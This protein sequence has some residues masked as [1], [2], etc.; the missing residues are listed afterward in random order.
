[1]DYSLIILFRDRLFA[2]RNYHQNETATLNEINM[3]GYYS[4]PLFLKNIWDTSIHFS[5]KNIT[6]NET[7]RTRNIFDI[8]GRGLEPFYPNNT[9]TSLLWNNA[10]NMDFLSLLKYSSTLNTSLNFVITDLHEQRIPNYFLNRD[11]YTSL[12][13]SHWQAEDFSYILLNS[14]HVISWKHRK[15]NKIITTDFGFDANLLSIDL[16]EYLLDFSPRFTLLFKLLS[17]NQSYFQLELGRRN[18]K[19]NGDYARFLSDGYHSA[20]NYIWEDANSNRQAENNEISTD[21][22]STTGSKYHSVGKD[23]KQ[24]HYYYLDIP[25]GIDFAKKWHF[26]VNLHYRTFRD[27]AY[28]VHDKATSKP[29]KICRQYRN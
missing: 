12:Y 15:A 28:I 25:V 13:V 6:Q 1:M 9:I 19:Y 21:L 23:F 27:E 22:H 20:E 24:P 26:G 5:Y 14:E 29:N 2:D 7:N 4:H 16:E 10:F 11:T 3:T 17:K 18:I 8:T